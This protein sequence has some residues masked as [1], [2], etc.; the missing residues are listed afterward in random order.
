MIYEQ[1]Q[2]KRLVA[3]VFLQVGIK[4]EI[5]VIS[6]I[7]AYGKKHCVGYSCQLFSKITQSVRFCNERN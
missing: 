6:Y 2:P 3:L 4:C 5:K 7:S 1:T